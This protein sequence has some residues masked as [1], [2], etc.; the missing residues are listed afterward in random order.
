MIK[1]A[2]PPSSVTLVGPLPKLKPSSIVCGL[3]E[4]LTMLPASVIGFPLSVKAP[5]LERN[6]MS[7]A[8]SEGVSLVLLR[9]GG[10]PKKK[11]VLPGRIAPFQLAAVLQLLSSGLAPLQ[12]LDGMVVTARSI[13][14]LPVL[15]TRLPP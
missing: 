10:A 13:E 2:L 8:V 5:A 9:R 4:L 6:E 1:P 7:A 12:T 15:F 3:E 11:G 14:L